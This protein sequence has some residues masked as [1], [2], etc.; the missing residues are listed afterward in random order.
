MNNQPQVYS[1]IGGLDYE[2]ESF[3]SLQLFDCKSAAEKYKKELEDEY[4][5][6]LMQTRVINMESAI[7]AA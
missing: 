5:Y 7:L 4:D 2:G 1:V 3:I 6:V